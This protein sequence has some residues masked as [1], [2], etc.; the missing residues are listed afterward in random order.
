M[1]YY[2]NLERYLSDGVLYAKNHSPPQLGFRISFDD[3]VA[4]RGTQFKTPDG[5]SINNY[6]PFY[7]SPIT[8]MA[9]TIHIGNVPLKDASGECLGK[10]SMDDVAFIVVEPGRLFAS[11]RKCWFTNI[12][13]NSNLPVVYKKDPAELTTHIDWSLFDEQPTTGKIAEIEYEGVCRWQHDRDTLSD[14]SRSTKRM[15]EFMVNGHLKMTEVSCIVL[16]NSTHLA[17]I[18]SWIKAT[19]LD[20]PVLVKPGCYF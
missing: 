19:K 2:K 11:G 12:A 1:T 20:I 5:E 16:K 18:Q 4:R 15:A 17:E 10:A 9:Y 14:Q 3:I 13:C 8:K 6:V 7:F